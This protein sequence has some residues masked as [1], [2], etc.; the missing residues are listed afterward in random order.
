[1]GQIAAIYCRVSTGDQDCQRQETELLALAGKAGYT[2]AGI[3]KET[4]S[5][6]KSDRQQRQKIL[7]MA[8][9]RK[10]DL[11]LVTELTRWSRSTLDLF[12]TL[13]DLQSW[14][15]GLIA[16]TGLQFDLSTPQGKLIATLMSG[17]AE[18]ERDLLRE[19]VRSGVQ[20]AQARGVIFGRRPGQR[21]KSEKLTP[22]VLALIAEGCSYRQIGRQLD[23]SKNTVM[24]IVKREREK[25][26]SMLIKNSGL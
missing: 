6:S 26:E 18:F 19:R 7:N 9:A 17:F 25:V 1:M 22:K 13:N 10:I 11:V 4:A 24:A 3:W 23:L 2:I 8:Q 14:G 12:H 20:A 21:I 16:Q 15:V 5:G